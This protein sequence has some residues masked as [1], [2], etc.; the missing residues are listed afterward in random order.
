MKKLLVGICTV[1]VLF[2]VGCGSVGGLFTAHTA[3]VPIVQTNLVTTTLS[4]VASETVT[5][6]N[7]AGQPVTNIVTVTN[8]VTTTNTVLTTNLVTV[9]NSYTVSSTVSNAIAGA[10]GVNALTAGVDPYSL[11]IGLGLSALSAVLAFWGRQ[12]SVAAA[13]SASVAQTVI[14][15]VEGLEPAVAAGVKAAVT[16]QAAKAG[17]STIVANTVAAVTANLN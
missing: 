6:T 2:V 12:K 15:A 7:S 11:P 4:Q 16:A 3:V 1:S 8:L 13:K 9:T 5:N 14:T 10:Q 17:T